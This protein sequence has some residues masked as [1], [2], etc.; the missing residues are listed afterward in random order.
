MPKTKWTITYYCTKVRKTPGKTEMESRPEETV[1][2]SFESEDDVQRVLKLLASK[3]EGLSEDLLSECMD[4]P[5]TTCDDVDLK[6][7]NAGTCAS[8][9]ARKV[10]ARSWFTAHCHQP[11]G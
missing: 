8:F 7:K 4:A 11:K 5:E 2:C 9:N 1:T 10:N 3:D 6:S